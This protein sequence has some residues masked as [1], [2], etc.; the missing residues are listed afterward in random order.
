LQGMRSDIKKTAQRG[1]RIIGVQ[2][3]LQFRTGRS[4]AAWAYFNFSEPLI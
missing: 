2:A 3:E 4:G 1:Q